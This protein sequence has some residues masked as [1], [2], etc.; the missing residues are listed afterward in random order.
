[1]LSRWI[2]N[3]SDASGFGNI[4]V[5]AFLAVQALDG[6]L[7]YVGLATLGSHM[8]GNPVVASLMLAFGTGPGLT[9]AKVV[10]G[11][12][13]IAL[14]L[15]GVHRLVAVLT[16]IYLGAAIVPWTALLLMAG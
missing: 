5:V 1:M 8:E 2:F 10:A 11:A 6:V 3:R 13:G 4:A 9:G 12:L 15:T 7:T 16:A 14:H